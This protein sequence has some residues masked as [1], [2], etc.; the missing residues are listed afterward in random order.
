MKGALYLPPFSP[1]GG[2]LVVS[3]R[4]HEYMRKQNPRKL[5]WCALFIKILADFISYQSKSISACRGVED[6]ARVDT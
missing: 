4:L 3:Y 2:K 1:L 6:A 5:V